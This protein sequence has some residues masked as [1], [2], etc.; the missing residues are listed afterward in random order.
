MMVC[1][2]CLIEENEAVNLR[3]NSSL[4]GEDDTGMI[5]KIDV[6]ECVKSPPEGMPLRRTLKYEEDVDGSNLILSAK[7]SLATSAQQLPL[8]VN[9][10]RLNSV[11]HTTDDRRSSLSEVYQIGQSVRTNVVDVS[12]ETS[13]ITVSLKQSF[14]SSTDA[15]FIQEYFLVEEKVITDREFMLQ[16][17]P[18]GLLTGNIPVCLSYGVFSLSVASLANYFLEVASAIG[19]EENYQNIE[20]IFWKSVR[21]LIA[22]LQSVDSGGSDLRWVEQFNLSSTVKGRVH[23][24]KEFGVVVSFQ[25]CDDVFGFISHYQLSGIPVETGSS[26]R[27]ALLD[28]SKIECLVDLSLKPAFVN[29]SK[30]ETTNSQTQKIP[31]GQCVQL[32]IQW[33]MDCTSTLF[34]LDTRLL[35]TAGFEPVQVVSVPSYNYTLGYASRADCNTQNLPP[36]S[37]S[38]GESVIATVMAL[39]SPSTRGRL[40]LQLKSISEAIETSNSKRLKGNLLIMLDRWFGQSFHG[41]VHITEASDDNYTEAPFSNFRFGQ[42]LTARIISKFNISESVKSVYQWELSIKPSILAGYGEIEPIKKFSY[43]TGQLVSGFVYK[44]DSE[45]AWLTISRDVKAQLYILTSS[46]EP[47]ELDEFQKRFSVGRD[48]S[49]YV[50]SCNKEKKLVRLISHPLLIDPERPAC[51]EDGPTDHSSENM[52]FH[53]RKGSVLGGRISKILPGVG[54]LLVQIDPYLYGKVHFTELTDSGVTDPLSGYHEGQFVKCKVLGIAHSGKG[55]V[56]IDLSLRSISHKTQKQKLSALNDS[57]NTH[58]LHE[59]ECIYNLHWK[60]PV[61]VDKIEDLHPDMMVQACVKNVTPKGCFVMRSRKV[62]AK[63][64]LSN[65]SD[66]YVENPEK[67]FPVGKLVMG[68]VVSM[69]PLSKRVEVTLRTSSAVGAPSSDYDALSDLTVG[70]VI[71][72]RVKRVE[73]YGLFITVDH[74]NLVGLCHVSEISDNH[75]DTIDSRHK[76][77]DRVTAKILKVDRERHRILLGMKKL[78]FNDATSTETD[79]RPSSGYTVNGDALSIGIESTPSP[80]KSSQGREDLDGESVDGKDLFLAEV[81]SQASIPPLEVPLDDTEN[82]D[83]DD[84]VNEDSG[85]KKL[86]LPRKDY[87]KKIFPEMKM[88][89]RN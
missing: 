26:I 49:G 57:V 86:E 36:K 81:E 33:I 8:D 28:V 12:S 10:V 31:E 14:C 41:R 32:E 22:K 46:S 87:W 25:K 42:T 6:C 34:Y 18:V 76:T 60:F 4:D 74:T 56:H 45:W 38:N 44:V 69:E 83:M 64:L 68:K 78:Y 29:K 85:N 89:L 66:G 1:V 5:M 50:L 53:I 43:S 71:S 20:Q 80:E 30:K 3:L 15:S 39:P 61:L 54:G 62:D 27:T 2:K 75:V 55:T 23:E 11:L 24:I 13:R 35:F 77:G 17:S 40:L 65:L 19:R 9:Q 21:L 59:P 73:P 52:A 51:Q 47:S 88:S 84:V 67:E 58:E 63:V 48:F 82:L 72:G 70:N 37:F 16:K 79:A 7:H